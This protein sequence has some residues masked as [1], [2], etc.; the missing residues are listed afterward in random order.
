MLAIKYETIKKFLRTQQNNQDVFLQKWLHCGNPM[1]FRLHPPLPTTKIENQ[2]PPSQAEMSEYKREV[3]VIAFIY[4]R[5][6]ES[7][8]P[9][10]SR[11]QDTE[12]S[13]F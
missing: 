3:G 6:K 10:W 2:M 5:T 4:K 9:G 11:K 12:V 8:S 1:Q 13:V 7:R